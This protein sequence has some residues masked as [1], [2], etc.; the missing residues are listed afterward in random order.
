MKIKVYILDIRNINEE[1]LLSSQ[2][3]KDSFETYKDDETRKE[4]I[5]SSILKNKYI[6]QYHLNEYGK[7][8]SE[9]KCFNIS[10]SHGLVVL[11]IDTVDVGIDVEQIRPVDEKLKA[12]I[13]NK[14]EKEYIKDDETFFEI[15]TNKEALVKAKGI[16]IKE[17]VKDIPSL[18]INGVRLYKNE[19]YINQTIRY[20][21]Y[22][23]TVSRK[24]LD[25]PELEI[26]KV[27]I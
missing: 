6:G 13:S 19:Q 3:V 10:H 23:I 8:I 1:A 22:I 25:A 16:G 14:E 27:E 18:P 11:V 15:W 12:Y 9:E 26:E 20:L 17:K 2:Y 21:D 24:A 5:A 7:P 4:K